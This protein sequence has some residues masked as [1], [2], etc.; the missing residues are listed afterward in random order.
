MD[1]PGSDS[2]LIWPDLPLL[3]R[4]APG[5]EVCPKTEEL[6]KDRSG[7]VFSL[8]KCRL[9][10][11]SY[12]VA[13]S[14]DLSTPP[15]SDSCIWRPGKSGVPRKKGFA[16]E[17]PQPYHFLTR[18]E[19]CKIFSTGNVLQLLAQPGTTSTHLWTPTSYSARETPPGCWHNR[20][21]PSAGARF[22]F[23][24]ISSWLRHIYFLNF[25]IS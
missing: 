15:A 18:D 4:T 13:S 25:I 12:C 2:I 20:V 3:N 24:W 22:P 5:P 8:Y 19:R 9:K 7:S 10:L 23:F 11:P 6:K 16:S 1:L 14:Q 17:N 21:L